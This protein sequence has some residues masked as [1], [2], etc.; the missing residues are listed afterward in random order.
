MFYTGVFAFDSCATMWEHTEE[1]V[2]DDDVLSWFDEKAKKDFLLYPDGYVSNVGK[3]VTIHIDKELINTRAVDE[4]KRTFK[5]NDPN[6]GLTI[7][8]EELNET[9]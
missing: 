5:L 8:V 1:K 9:F 2:F 4:V 6:D 7:I 3:I